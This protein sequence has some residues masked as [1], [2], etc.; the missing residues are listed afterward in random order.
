M[1]N[2]SGRVG[3]KLGWAVAMACAGMLACALARAEDLVEVYAL[4]RAN[5]PTFRAANDE[6]NAVSAAEPQ[7]LAGLLPLITFEATRTHTRQDI[8]SSTNAVYQ[9]GATSYPSKEF[10]LSLTQPIFRLGAWVGYQQ[11]KVKVKQAVAIYGAAEQDLILRTATA[12]VNVLASKD[13]LS[14]SESELAAIKSQLDLVEQRYKSGQVATVGMYD[15]KARYLLKQADVT[16]AQKDVNDQV[17]ALRELTGIELRNLRPVREDMPLEGPQPSSVD[18]WL[19]G[20]AEK[21]LTLEGRRQGVEVARREVERIRSGHAP[22]LD[23]V[24]TGDRKDT[25]GS[26]FGGGSV[27]QTTDV[28]ARLSVPIYSGGLIN[29]QTTEAQARY[30]QAQNLMDRDMR[31]IERQTRAAYEGLTSGIVRLQALKES[32]QAQESARNLKSEGF[33]AGLQTIL[34]VLDSERDLYAVKRDAAK[35]RYE[36]LLNRLRLKQA[37]G[38]LSDE[39]LSMLNKASLQQR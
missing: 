11:S 4:A 35:S 38:T 2:A 6:L 10:V 27:I 13:A 36:F 16:N 12:Y 3:G 14:F 22:S 37:V 5:D 28:M 18:A 25:G 8:I 31:Q 21:N 20:A 7:A 26:L 1:S 32:V 29:A 9:I 24:V 39:D 15:A 19:Q 17:Q 33:K 23:L 30:S 34:A